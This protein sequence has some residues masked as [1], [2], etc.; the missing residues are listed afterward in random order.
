MRPFQLKQ[1]HTAFF[2]KN[3]RGN[4]QSCMDRAL[5]EKGWLQKNKT[6]ISARVQYL[7][8][9][10]CRTAPEPSVRMPSET[11]GETVFHDTGYFPDRYLSEG[12][13]VSEETEMLLHNNSS[14]AGFGIVGYFIIIDIYAPKI[15]ICRIHHEQGGG[16][17]GFLCPIFRCESNLRLR[18][19]CEPRIR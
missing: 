2:L 9:I 10:Y 12:F 3:R 7:P 13:K 18:M 8:D 4:G 17:P 11:T 1:L 19:V 5:Q 14:F 16:G 15:T 6:M